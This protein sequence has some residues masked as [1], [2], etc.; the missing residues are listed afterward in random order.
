MCVSLSFPSSGCLCLSHYF[1][2]G[3]HSFTIPFPFPFPL[4]FPR[5]VPS[6]GL[7]FSFSF[8]LSFPF[9]S[10][11]LAASPSTTLPSVLRCV[12]RTR[13]RIFLIS[14]LL[15]IAPCIFCP[16]PFP[17]L[18]VPPPPPP[19][20]HTS[21]FLHSAPPFQYRNP[22]VVPNISPRLERVPAEPALAPHY[23][24][25]YPTLHAPLLSVSSYVPVPPS[26]S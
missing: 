14:R 16:A 11:L 18:R 25:C 23:H 15:R 17:L 22:T 9:R 24:L 19:P 8:F 1:A 12:H 20:L 10:S 3:L 7:S 26:C 13:H 21:L 2:H 5:A 4:I 6:P